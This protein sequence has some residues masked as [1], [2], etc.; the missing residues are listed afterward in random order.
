MGFYGKST[1]L[2]TGLLDNVAD[3]RIVALRK[4]LPVM[5]ATAFFPID[6]RTDNQLRNRN[7]I[8]TGR[9]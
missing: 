6:S 3:I 2:F 7:K 9:V 1:Y 5:S 8:L 4:I